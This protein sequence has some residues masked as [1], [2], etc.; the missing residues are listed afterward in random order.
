MKL[1]YLSIVGGTILILF[2]P[3]IVYA[4]EIVDP[5]TVEVST[6][7]DLDERASD[8]E[9]PTDEN[10]VSQE[11]TEEDQG[12]DDIGLIVEEVVSDDNSSV[13]NEELFEHF[14]NQQFGIEEEQTIS[15]EQTKSIKKASRYTGVELQGINATLYDL[16]SDQISEVA[17]GNKQSTVF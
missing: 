9:I 7:N 4:D 8:F 2:A 10:D 11:V 5:V 14:V 12:S 17:I 16:L 1:N 6:E 13:S 15:N 3:S